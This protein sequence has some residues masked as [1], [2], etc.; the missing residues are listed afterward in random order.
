M[1]INI[2]YI[3][4]GPKPGTYRSILYHSWQ[5]P[6]KP[7]MFSLH[8][9]KRSTFVSVRQHIRREVNVTKPPANSWTVLC[10]VCLKIGYL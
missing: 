6:G 8:I 4:Y 7:R 5:T 9:P 3:H 10:M 2:I 1:I